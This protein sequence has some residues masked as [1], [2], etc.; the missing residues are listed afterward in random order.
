M[1]L[2]NFGLIRSVIVK[3]FNE[4]IEHF[5]RLLVVLDERSGAHP[6]IISYGTMIVCILFLLETVAYLIF[7]FVCSLLAHMKK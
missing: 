6:S 4:I 7:L 5:D 3:I 2:P 1:F